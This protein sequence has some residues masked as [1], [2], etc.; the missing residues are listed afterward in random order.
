M[1]QNFLEI[2]IIK[3]L[4]IICGKGV[5]HLGMNNSAIF[6]NQNFNNI[7]TVETSLYQR[8]NDG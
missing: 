5:Q 4:F 8:C 2:V 6:E 3:L 7:I 1:Y